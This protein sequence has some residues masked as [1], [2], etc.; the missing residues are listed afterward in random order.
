MEVGVK[1]VTHPRDSLHPK[2]PEGGE[3]CRPCYAAHGQLIC[4]SETAVLATNAVHGC[5]QLG[6]DTAQ[7]VVVQLSDT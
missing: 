4:Y 5:I 7:V 2:T 1:G 3:A 6:N